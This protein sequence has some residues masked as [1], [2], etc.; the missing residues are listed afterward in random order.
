MEF[1]GFANAVA[2]K[3]RSAWCKFKAW[4]CEVL[5]VLAYK[6]INKTWFVE[7]PDKNDLERDDGEVL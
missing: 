3:N 4:I 1:I 6:K 7:K 5:W 2:G